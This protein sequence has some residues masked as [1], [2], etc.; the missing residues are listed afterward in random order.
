MYLRPS[1]VGD[2]KALWASKI[3]LSAMVICALYCTSSW[4]KVFVSRFRGAHGIWILSTDDSYTDVISPPLEWKG[5][6]LL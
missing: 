6:R 1:L 4:W 2:E 5:E 3:L